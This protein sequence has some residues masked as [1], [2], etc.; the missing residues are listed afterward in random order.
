[1]IAAEQDKVDDCH[2]EENHVIRYYKA[3][4]VEGRVA[5][6]RNDLLGLSLLFP[7]VNACTP[8]KRLGHFN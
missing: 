7:C 6:G 1:M 4:I 2:E 8:G 3:R 5:C